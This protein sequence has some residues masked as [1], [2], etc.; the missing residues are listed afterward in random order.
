MWTP[1]RRKRRPT[2]LVAYA[3]LAPALVLMVPFQVYPVLEA[4][5]LS[6]HRVSLTRLH[7]PQFVGLDNYLRIAR[8]QD[9]DFVPTVLANTARFVSGSLLLQ[10]G[11]GLLLALLV[12]QTWVRGRPVFRSIY[13]IPWVT[14]GVIAAYSWR[15]IYDPRTGI[16]NHLVVRAGG[17][18]QS[19][20]AD[21]RLSMG[22]LILANTWKGTAFS[23]LVQT[24]GLQSIDP[25][26]YDAARVDGASGWQAT[27]YVTLPL[28]RPFLLI[29]LI[30][31]SLHTLNVFDLI[32][33][34]TGGG[35]LFSTE[36]MSLFMYHLA[37]E[38]GQLGLGAAVATVILALSLAL[39]LLYVR[40]LR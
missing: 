16:L 29:N 32:Y 17:A 4:V 25:E 39:T 15:F 8:Y 24:A 7:A 40:A 5:W 20:L 1:V 36:V 30:I 18:P 12:H 14:T 38:W 9:P 10:M 22:S 31:A 26:L 3:L 13:L 27:L 21:P 35:P 2:W 19:W 37:F 28:L 33:V 23:F 11:L 34:T 6:L